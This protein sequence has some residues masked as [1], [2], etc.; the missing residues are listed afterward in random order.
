MSDNIKI[1]RKN[2]SEGVNFTYIPEEKFKTTLISFSM[3]V[4]LDNKYVSS[5]ALLADLLS[6]SCEKYTK[7]SD[8]SKKLEDLYGASI[9]SSVTKLG[10]NHVI[11][12]SATGLNSKYA[13][14]NTNNILELANILC[15]MIFDPDVNTQEKSFNIENFNQEKRQ[16]IEDINSELNNKKLYAKKRCTE[17][18]CANEKFSINSLGTIEQA[19]KLTPELVYQAWEKLLN[20]SR[21]EIIVT[22]VISCEQ[23]INLFQTKFS[24]I[25]R[26]NINNFNTE[27]IKK[28]HDIKNITEYM[29]ITQSKLVMGFRTEISEGDDKV[30]AMI[31]MN[32]LYGGNAQSKLFLNVREKQS[33]CY[34][35][36]SRYNKHKGVM[37]VE[38]GV[39]NNNIEKAKKEILAQ[40]KQIQLGNFTDSELNEIKLYVSQGIK[41][42]KDS[43]ESLN[44]WYISQ[45]FSENKNTPDDIIDKINHVTREE[46]IEVANK[47]TLDTVYVLTSNNLTK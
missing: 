1:V 32:S 37:F 14:N 19:E 47:I 26:K 5:N 33:L 4:P 29:D 43:L 21:I 18:M 6:H 16:L 24:Q 46:I 28:A 35:C 11:T 31:L 20:N 2:L 41:H 12:L 36:S 3:F 27:I 15:D 8:I 30:H 39:E 23:I 10:E 40:L 45:V 44:S 38:S 25:N 7:I 9:S 22:G 42:T 13:Q 34:Y 17:I